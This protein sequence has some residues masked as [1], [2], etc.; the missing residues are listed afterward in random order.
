MEGPVWYQNYTWMLD[1][2]PLPKPMDIMAVNV[3]FAPAI[4]RWMDANL[5]KGSEV[6]TGICRDVFERLHS[7]ADFSLVNDPSEAKTLYMR[8]KGFAEC[9]N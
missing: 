2:P 4:H 7:I 9:G 3:L 8:L 6:R 1:S 5:I